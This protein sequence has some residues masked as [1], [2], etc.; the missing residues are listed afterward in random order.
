M[1]IKDQ[2][3]KDEMKRYADHWNY[4]KP[5]NLVPNDRVL[6][7]KGRSHQRKTGAYYEPRP[8][9]VVDNKG[10]MVTA[11]GGKH[12]LQ[13]TPAC[14]N[15]SDQ[16]QSP[17]RLK[18]MRKVQRMASWSNPLINHSAL[19]NKGKLLKKEDRASREQLPKTLKDFVLER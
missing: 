2:Q 4:A 14:S 12:V 18:V 19:V 5:L 1:K 10:S 3:S 16:L 7:H 8:Y 11:L 15:P 9:T 13:E 6:V 17:S